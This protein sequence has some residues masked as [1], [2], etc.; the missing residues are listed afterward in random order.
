MCSAG[1]HFILQC[2]VDI[3][4]SSSS[5][6]STIQSFRRFF[7]AFSIY[8]ILF[9]Y[10]LYLLL[11]ITRYILGR[12]S[13]SS[14][15]PENYRSVYFLFLLMNHSITGLL[16]IGLLGFNLRDYW[17]C[18]TEGI[19]MRKV[20]GQCF[21]WFYRFISRINVFLKNSVFRNSVL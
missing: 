19:I 18:K 7:N 15:C 16:S 4:S 1:L 2:P 10:L 3:S 11:I 14:V 6:W 13:G 5:H 9:I 21:P 12:C 20:S 8:S 17:I